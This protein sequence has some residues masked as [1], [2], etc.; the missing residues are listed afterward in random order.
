MPEP[1]PAAFYA[2]TAELVAVL[3]EPAW[4]ALGPSLSAALAGLDATAGAVVDVGAGTGLGTS[5]IAQA[6]P[7]AHVVAVEPDR[8]LRTALLARIAGDAAMR[9]RVTVLDSDLLSADLPDR[10]AGLVAMNVIGHFTPADRQR[11]WELLA[12]RL[13]PGGRAVLNLYPPHEPQVVPPSQ[14]AEVT[15][16]RRRYRG[17]A[18]ARPAGSDAVVWEMTYT[19]EQD[20]HELSSFSARDDWYVLSPAALAEEVGRHGL[21]LRSAP[22]DLQIIEHAPVAPPP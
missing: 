10:I 19:V 5:V 17:S 1:S 7:D 12:Q 14:L 20:G 22:S 2:R 11:I 4:A 6:L 13:T 21:H 16:G 15:L 8:A 3:L 18:A 9:S